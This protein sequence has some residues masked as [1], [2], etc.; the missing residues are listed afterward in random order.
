MAQI[1]GRSP[2]SGHRMAAKNSACPLA[3]RQRHSLQGF[4]CH[5]RNVGLRAMSTIF[6]PSRP[7]ANWRSMGLLLAGIVAMLPGVSASEE[8]IPVLIYDRPPYYERQAGGNFVGLVGSPVGQAFER[9]GIAFVW[10][11]ALLHTQLEEIRADDRAVCAA[12]WFKTE[13]REEYAR[14]TIPVY[15]DQPLV[16]VGRSDNRRLW[17]STFEDLIVQPKLK[18][19]ARID[20]SFGAKIDGMIEDSGLTVRLSATGA[21]ENLERIVRGYADFLLISPEELSVTLDQVYGSTQLVTRSFQDIPS[22][23]TR[24]IICSRS[25]SEDQIKLLDEAIAENQ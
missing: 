9:A 8:P 5:L 3:V 10:T 20:F 19:L 17:A 16:V 7:F 12:G 11:N 22:G 21:K 18:M 1:E 23:N 14:F 2:R 4:G 24:H 13:E 15:K 25:V 6:P